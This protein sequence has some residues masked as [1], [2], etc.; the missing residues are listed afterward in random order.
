MQVYRLTHSMHV[1]RAN[2]FFVVAC[3]RL[4]GRDTGSVAKCSVCGRKLHLV[5]CEVFA[6]N[7]RN[8]Y[9]VRPRSSSALN[10]FAFISENISYF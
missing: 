7:V 10:D 8:I 1:D 6:I 3:M 4:D 2:L 5:N 9:V